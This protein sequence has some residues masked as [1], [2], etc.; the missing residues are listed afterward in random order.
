MRVRACVYVCI[1]IQRERERERA[2]EKRERMI[3]T[4]NKRK[5]ETEARRRAHAEVLASPARRAYASGSLPPRRGASA[6]EG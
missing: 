5:I 1:E 2:G 6:S 4:P 3:Y